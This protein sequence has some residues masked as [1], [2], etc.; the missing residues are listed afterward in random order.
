[1]T[2]CCSLW[3]G[4][5]FTVLERACLR[6]VINQ[7]HRLTLYLYEV[8]PDVP[9]GITL[10]D[11][12]TILPYETAVSYITKGKIAIFADWFRYQLQ[13]LGRGIWLDC[14]AYL[15]RPLDGRASYLMGVDRPNG[16]IQNGVLRLPPDSE[17]LLG[18]LS[19]FEHPYIP[20]WVPWKPRLKAQFVNLIGGD[21]D[22][23]RLPWG[24]TG[25]DALTALAR[26]HGVYHNA[27][28]PDVLYPKRWEEAAWVLDPAIQL[29]DVI[30]PRTL[31]IHLYNEMIKSFKTKPA[32]KGSFLAR[33]QQEGAAAS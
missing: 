4:S 16:Q 8:C 22:L 3:F 33:I 26:R 30:T 15:L 19:M 32:P 21:V 25:P 14:D 31:S 17:V 1:M 11:A 10:A 23:A 9:E 13:A 27:L 7:G 24:T 18:L 20:R 12:N 28:E 29:E 2:E 6:S 5:D